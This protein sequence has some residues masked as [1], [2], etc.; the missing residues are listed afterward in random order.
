MWGEANINEITYFSYIYRI[1]AFV[2]GFWIKRR[3]ECL[4]SDT[5]SDTQ[6]P[7]V[8]SLYLKHRQN[9]SALSLKIPA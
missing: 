1:T 6:H 3:Q 2:Y 5:P 9:S 8:P 4:A 7:S